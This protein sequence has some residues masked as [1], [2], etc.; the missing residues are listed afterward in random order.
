MLLD[1]TKVLAEL[2]CF[3]K[4]KGAGD[5][6]ILAAIYITSKYANNPSLG[7]KIPAFSLGADTDTIASITGGLLGMLSGMDWIPTKWKEVQDYGCLVQIAE[8]L[9]AD[10]KKE[11]TKKMVEEAKAQ[12]NQWNAT[13]I[14][15]MRFVG[16]SN[17]PTEKKGIVIINKWQTTLGQTIYTKTFQP[18]Q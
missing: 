2:G 18:Y 12:N 9:M 8:L 1:D 10:D 17:V 7:I 6:A 3:D 16:S 5:V 13:P 11:A 15:K 4:A 14:G